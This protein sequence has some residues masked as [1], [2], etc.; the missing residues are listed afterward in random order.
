MFTLDGVPSQV[1]K[2]C[3]KW[4]IKDSLENETTVSFLLQFVLI[5]SSK[6]KKKLFSLKR[7]LPDL[8]LSQTHSL[9]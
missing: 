5:Q 6:L 4:A 2:T 9:N 3:R 1:I 7:I 8:I